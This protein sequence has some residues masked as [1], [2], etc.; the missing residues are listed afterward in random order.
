M[1]VAAPSTLMDAL[2]ERIGAA[3]D[4]NNVSYGPPENAPEYAQ[5]WIRYGERTFEYGM[6][7]V[8]HVPVIVTV[9][10]KS[11][12]DYRTEYREVNDITNTIAMALLAPVT[13]SDEL[14]LNGMAVSEPVR[15]DYAGQPGA[16][17][18]ATIT[19]DFE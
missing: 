4:S 5:A 8:E 9:A 13:I 19:L 15:A 14:T 17:M 6:F 1:T 2:V 12:S 11:G 7:A 18:A 16:I 10:V 3:W